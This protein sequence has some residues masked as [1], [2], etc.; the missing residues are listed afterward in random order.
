MSIWFLLWFVLA[1]I[2]LGTSLWSSIILFQQKQAW[3][4]YAAKKGLK[5]TPNKFSESP[6]IE[7]VIEGFNISIFSGLQQKEDARKN[8]QLT[9]VQINANKPF[10]DSIGAGTKEMFL[11][12]GSLEA[13]TPHEVKVEKWDKTYEIRSSNKSAVDAYL[14]EERVSILT[15]ILSMPKADI[16]ILLDANDGVFRVETSNPLQSEALLSS[17]VDKLI[18]R[19][20]KLVPSADEAKNLAAIIKPEK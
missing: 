9:V 6:T 7:G 2:I 15:S 13:I 19:I 16:L 3:K 1:V 14:T 5:Y 8:R 11:F 12:L 18:V 10:V 17:L 20:K 4:A